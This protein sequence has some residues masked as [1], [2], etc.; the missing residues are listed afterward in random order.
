MQRGHFLP[1]GWCRTVQL[2]L[3][4]KL[5]KLALQERTSSYLWNSSTIPSKSLWFEPEPVLLNV[6]GPPKLIP[7]NEFR[8]PM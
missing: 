6:Y 1:L 5:N 4:G 8:Q 3:V 7:R 2:I